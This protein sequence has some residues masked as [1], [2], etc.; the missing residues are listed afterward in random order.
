M[1]M[2]DLKYASV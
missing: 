2:M 1:D